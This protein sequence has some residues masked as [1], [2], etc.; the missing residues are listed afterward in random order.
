MNQE[1]VARLSAQVDIEALRAYRIAVGRRTREI[2][3]QLKP[4]EGKQKIEP[5]RLQQLKD[6]GAVL[7]EAEWLIRYW[8]RLNK[9]GL[10]LMPPTRH[11][12]VHLNEAIRLKQKSIH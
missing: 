6:A 5:S 10:L 3:N 11:N 12:F 8:G 1:E 7:D 9:A 2:I 4:G